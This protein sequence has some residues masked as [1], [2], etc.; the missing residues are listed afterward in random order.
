MRVRPEERTMSRK[1]VITDTTMMTR[2][3]HSATAATAI[4]G[5]TRDVR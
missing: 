5:M 3:T 4:R 2:A 1:P